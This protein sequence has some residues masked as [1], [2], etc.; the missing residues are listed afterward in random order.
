[1]YIFTPTTDYELYYIGSGFTEDPNN[2]GAIGT[3]LPP[4]MFT[5]PGTMNICDALQAC[6]TDS[7][8]ASGDWSLALFFLAS[9]SSWQCFGYENGQN[10]PTAFNVP[11]PDVIEGYGYSVGL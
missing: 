5:Y 1:M 6:A 8:Q 11:N 7:L 3:V 4:D 9:T 2:A 10:D